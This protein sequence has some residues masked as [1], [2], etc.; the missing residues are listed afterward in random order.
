MKT[1][2]L[3]TNWHLAAPIERVWQALYEVERW[4]QWW[5]HVLAVIELKK[6]DAQGVGAVR[7]Y[8]W[9]SKLPY[10]LTFE[11]RA[12][13]VERPNV[14]EGVAYG[15]LDGK[16]C[17][18]L[19]ADGATTH[20]RYQWDVMTSRAWMNIVAP[21]MAPVFRWNHNQVMAAGAQGLAKHLGVALLAY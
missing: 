19:A 4:P 12:T 1:Y 6:G 5:P 18:T 16:G 15:E 21:L 2:S 7:R 10:R 14:L 8:T 11:M 13:V 9:S 17:W 3:T 20:A